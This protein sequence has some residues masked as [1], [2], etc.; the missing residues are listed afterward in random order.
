[1]RASVG[2][3]LS[4]VREMHEF[5]VRSVLPTVTVPTTLV[6]QTG[7]RIGPIGGAHCMAEQMPRAKLV[8][9]AGIDHHNPAPLPE[10][11]HTVLEYLDDE[12]GRVGDLGDH[13]LK[14]P[15]DPWR[16]YAVDPGEDQ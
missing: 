3:C 2:T 7:D 11:A 14:G 1:M 4:W 12:R 10:I 13:Q 9:I 15:D 8:E 16:C 5:D 6:H